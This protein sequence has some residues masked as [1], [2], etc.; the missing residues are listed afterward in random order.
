MIFPFAH[1]HIHTD[2]DT[3]ACAHTHAYT[4]THIHIYCPSQL[5]SL[6]LF[7]LDALCCNPLCYSQKYQSSLQNL[8]PY[9]QFSGNFQ[10]VMYQ[11]H[12]EAFFTEP[13][14]VKFPPFVCKWNLWFA[15]SSQNMEKWWRCFSNV[16]KMP[17]H[18]ILSYAKRRILCLCEPHFIKFNPLKKNFVPLNN[19][20]L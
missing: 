8:T 11:T 6:G 19:S 15:F 10:M 16:L 2:T 1:L 3:C 14:F 4:H 9:F 13:H 17:T 7:H 18:L 5:E 20:I 12:P